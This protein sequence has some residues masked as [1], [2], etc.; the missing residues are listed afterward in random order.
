MMEVD[1]L[2]QQNYIG[3]LIGKKL[4]IALSLHGINFTEFMVLYHLNTVQERQLSRI[5]LAEKVALS[6]SGITRVLIPMEK[7]GLVEKN[8]NPRDARQSLVLLTQSGKEIMQNAIIT[9]EHTAEAV[10]S[11]FDKGEI[12]TLIS[13]LNKL[14]L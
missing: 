8:T 6:A 7:I 12:L 10:F 9:V 1:F 13:L 2:I 4:D 14:K 5:A 3:T 11:L